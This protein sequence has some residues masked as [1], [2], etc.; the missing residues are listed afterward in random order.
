MLTKTFATPGLLLLSDQ[1]VESSPET[2]AKENDEEKGVM[3][4][5]AK[6]HQSECRQRFRWGQPSHDLRPDDLSHSCGQD[7]PEQRQWGHLQQSGQWRETL[8]KMVMQ[9]CASHDCR[10]CR[11]MGWGGVQKDG[12]G[13]W[14]VGWGAEGWGGVLK[15]GVGCRHMGWGGVQKDGV[16]LDAER[17]GG[18]G[19]E[20]WGGVHK[21]GVGWSA[22]RWG[23]VQKDGVGCVCVYIVMPYV[24]PSVCVFTVMPCACVY[25]HAMC[26]CLVM[27]CACV[28]SHALCVCVFTVM[29]CVCV[30]LHSQDVCVCVCVFS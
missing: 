1:G 18:W 12:V 3:V 21:D 20:G 9:K 8:V 11:K 7:D 5:V 16:G 10:S 23:V 26:V 13:C 14:K 30:C 19:V 17:W 2:H 4:V 6:L 15:G 22:E 27:P 24:V 28:Y 25:S 29:P